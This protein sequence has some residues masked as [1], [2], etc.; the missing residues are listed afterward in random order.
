[1]IRRIE[2][3]N[4]AR[5]HTKNKPDIIKT[6]E[7]WRFSVIEEAFNGVQRYVKGDLK[8]DCVCDCCGEELKRG[9]IATASTLYR[10]D[11]IFQNWE[12]D[13]IE[14]HIKFTDL[15]NSIE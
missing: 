2:C 15:L 13:Y 7:G 5:N 1:M 8:F 10:E 4:C 11:E 12:W 14:P 6:K 3:F 9:T